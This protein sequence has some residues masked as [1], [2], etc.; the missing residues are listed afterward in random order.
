MSGNMLTRCVREK[1]GVMSD[2]DFWLNNNEAVRR[3][4]KVHPQFLRE[5]V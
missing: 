2:E 5:K 3:G 1:A 4:G